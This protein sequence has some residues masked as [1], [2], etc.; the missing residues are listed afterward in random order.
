M[1]ASHEAIATTP[2]SVTSKMPFILDG[3]SMS[4]ES[5]DPVSQDGDIQSSSHSNSHSYSHPHSLNISSSSP[6]R[7]LR[8]QSATA[9]LHLPARIQPAASETGGVSQTQEAALVNGSPRRPRASTGASKTRVSA[10]RLTEEDASWWT[11]EIHK[12]REI[13]RRWKEA[14]DENTVIIGNKVDTN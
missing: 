2:A 8:T 1:P 13:R 9:L 5:S 11:E 3:S 10:E 6:P 4:P 7:P 14:E 12:R